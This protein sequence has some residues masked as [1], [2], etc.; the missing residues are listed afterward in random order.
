MAGTAIEKRVFVTLNLLR[1]LFLERFRSYKYNG[2]AWVLSTPTVTTGAIWVFMNQHVDVV[3]DYAVPCPDCTQRQVMT[4]EQI[5]FGDER[6]PKKVEKEKLARYVCIHCGVQWDDRACDKAIQGGVWW[7]RLTEKGIK[8]GKQ[9][10]D[11]FTTLQE[12]RPKNICFH[13]PAWISRLVSLSE[14]AAAFL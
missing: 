6:D 5:R 9:P 4:F 7:E 11:L 14:T 10:R 1:R 12:D 13:S 8:A 3:F 2:K